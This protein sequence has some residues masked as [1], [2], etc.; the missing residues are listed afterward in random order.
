MVSL[1]GMVVVVGWA[2]C[3]LS[4]SCRLMILSLLSLNCCMVSLLVMV[5]VVGWA[6]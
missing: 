3:S 1:L 4:L 6:S 5:V 2:S